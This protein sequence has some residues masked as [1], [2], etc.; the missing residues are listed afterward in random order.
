MLYKKTASVCNE[1]LEIIEALIVFEDGKVFLDKECSK[2]WKQR[3]KLED[4]EEYYKL[5]KT[6]YSDWVD[7]NLYEK[8]LTHNVSS[9][10]KCIFIAEIT[11]KCNMSCPICYANSWENK[12]H[13]SLED[14][15]KIFDTILK[16]EKNPDIVQISGW[17]PTIHPDFFSI[18]KMAREKK[19]FRYLMVNTNGVKIANDEQF[20]SNL[21]QFQPNFEIYLQFDSFNDEYNK[22][23]RWKEMKE[24]RKKAIENLNKYNISTTLVVVVSEW[25]ISELWE[26]IDFASKQSCIRWIT[27]Q[28]AQSTWRNENKLATDWITISRIRNEIIKQTWVFKESDIVPIPCHPDGSSIAYALKKNWELTP[29]IRFVE[30]EDLIN[31]FSNK[32]SF[33]QDKKFI[34]EVLKI[35]NSS[36]CSGP[37]NKVSSNCFWWLIEIL[38]I[39][40]NKESLNY[41]NIF[42]ITILQFFDKYNFEFSAV[43][44]ACIFIANEN[45]ELYLFDTYNTFHRNKKN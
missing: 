13:K 44:Q 24:I 4:S 33:E 15:E 19:W 23:I 41:D 28:V 17:E 37:N 38:A 40:W 6:Y 20:V 32:I 1:C 5:Q 35:Q 34:S 11:D 16:H 10:H 30:K 8:D 29:L 21:K 9:N 36:C 3:A 31:S 26:L 18:I 7:C 27:L 22:K 25:N 14:I 39:L 45:W 43:K 42:R 12:N 2:H